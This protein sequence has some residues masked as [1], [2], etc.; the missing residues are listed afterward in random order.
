MSTVSI[1]PR[2][3]EDLKDFKSAGCDVKLNWRGTKN[4]FWMITAPEDG[5]FRPSV[6]LDIDQARAVKAAL[7]ELEFRLAGLAMPEN[8]LVKKAVAA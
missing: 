3:D 6:E 2:K 8:E 5:P 4:P 1:A 7:E